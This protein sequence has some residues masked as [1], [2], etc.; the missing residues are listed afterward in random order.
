ME[1]TVNNKIERNNNLRFILDE[2]INNA[3]NI[4]AEALNGLRAY[5]K[6]LSDDAVNQIYD[7]LY[8]AYQEKMSKYQE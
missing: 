7:D 6:E 5:I 4:S 3:L 2:R 1:A 8:E